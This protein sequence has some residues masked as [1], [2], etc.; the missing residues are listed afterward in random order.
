MTK[1]PV[2]I[3][4]DEDVLKWVDSRCGELGLNRS[5]FIEQVIRDSSVEHDVLSQ[6]K[7]RDMLGALASPAV[8]DAL[9][10]ALGGALGAREKRVVSERLQEYRKPVDTKSTKRT[11]RSPKK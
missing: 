2:S 4:L 9:S 1:I 11:S 10:N 6:P 8:I 5:V 3:T 7:V